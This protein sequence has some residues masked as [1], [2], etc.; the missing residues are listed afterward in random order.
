VIEK[1]KEIVREA[2]QL[3]LN[4]P[5]IPQNALDYFQKKFFSPN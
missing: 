3:G 5:G 2:Q 1:N 4:L